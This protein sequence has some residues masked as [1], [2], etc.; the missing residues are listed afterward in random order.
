MVNYKIEYLNDINIKDIIKNIIKEMQVLPDNSFIKYFDTECAG[1]SNNDKHNKI[2][3]DIIQS[4]PY[5]DEDY[6][7]DPEH[8]TSWRQIKTS[9]DLKMR[10][11]CPSYSSYKIQHKA[12]RRFNYDYFVSFFDIDKILLKSV[13]LEF[14]YNATSIDETPQFV[15]PMN[16]SQ[17]LSQSFEEYYYFNYLIPLFNKFKITVPELDIYL[18]KVHGNK[19][20]CLEQAQ[21]LYYQGCKQS[22]KYDG[23][24]NAL[25]F[26]T[27]CKEVSEKCIKKFISETDLDIEKLNQYLIKSQDEKIYLLY[28][29][30]EF[31]IQF[32]NPDDYIIKTYVKD[33]N[34]YIGTSQSNKK[35]KILLRWKNGNGIAYPAFQIS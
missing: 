1:R 7:N 11:I 5:I 23:T 22:S 20:V 21:T 6:F 27:E 33:N 29:N 28:K 10:E 8:G 25:A 30:N 4:M 17:Y 18:E 35:V 32:S 31:H 19:P 26:Y 16:P 2:R 24:E 14:K 9:F 3:E 15:S 34:Q 13:K 12:G